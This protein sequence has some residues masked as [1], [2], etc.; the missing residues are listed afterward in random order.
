MKAPLPANEAQRL[1]TLR[2]YAVLDTPAELAYDDLALLAAQICQVPTAMVSLV[3][4]QRQWFKAR[5]G[6][7]ASE[8]SRD[9]AFCAHTILHADQVFEVRD[10]AADARF[11]ANPLVVSDPHMRFYAGA[12][13]VAPGGHA[14][15]ALCV[16][17][18][19]PRAL[20]AEQRSALQAL[21]R[22]VVA[23][24]ELRRQAREL[25]AKMAEGERHLSIAERSRRALLSILEDE[26]HAA[27]KLRESEARFRQIAENIQEVFWITDPAKNAILYVSPAYESIWGRPCQSLYDEPRNWLEAIHGDDRAAV[28][29]AAMTRQ[30]TGDYHETYRIMR[31]DG[32]PRWIR[33]RAFPVRNDQGEVYRVVGIAVDITEHK[34]AELRVKVQQEVTAVLAEAVSVPE[35][36]RRILEIICQRMD[37]VAGDLWIEDRATHTLRCV[38]IWHQPG[39]Q[40][41]AFAAATR[42]LTFAEGEGLPGRVWSKR[43]MSWTP[44]ISQDA[45]FVRRAHAVALG[46]RGAIAIP[47][48]LHGEAV[49][50]VEFFS[51]SSEEPEAQVKSMFAGFGTQ[52]GQFIERKHLEEQFRQAQKMEAIGTLAGGIAHDFNNVLSAITGYTELARLE[53]KGNPEV[54]EYLRAVAEGSNRAAD[55]VRQILAFSRLQEPRRKTIQLWPVVEEALKLLRATIPSTIEFETSLARGG[56][57]VLADPTQV[58]QVLM[59]LATNAAHA[60]KDRPGRLGVTL[61]NLEVDAELASTHPGLRVGRYQR[62]AVSDNGHG[63]DAGTLARI[64]DPFFTTKAPGEG[65]GLGLAVVHG[66]MQA[67]EGVITVYSQPGEGTRF[68]LYFPAHTEGA[69]V[70]SDATGEIPRGR[71]QHILLVDDE[72]PLAVMGRRILE[73]LGYVVDSYTAPADAL[74]A[75]RAAPDRF[76]LVV[77]DLTMPGMTGSDLAERLL[78][79]RPDLPIILTTGF[80]ATLTPER[81]R[82]LGVRELLLKPLT[83]QALGEAVHRTINPQPPL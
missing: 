69:P 14:L 12:P 75:V 57:T 60:M 7:E 77:S 62:L 16:M 53:A 11:A 30:V 73:R 8:T 33:D 42:P 40:Y 64:F 66:I 63:M 67:H 2:D 51:R 1:A 49:G 28:L 79:L 50:V 59:N 31:P 72:R 78:R 55:L 43:Q 17:D 24:L 15:G 25:A 32:T 34:R 9:I 46:L 27:R 23:Q 19:S 41:A 39:P 45:A 52:I 71:G 20:T 4:D 80:S 76:A 10:A 56:L 68:N 54:L 35:T 5:V 18:R 74:E 29:E 3:D 47:I 61:E 21:S 83:V 44:D 58:H 26:K 81:V 22:Q 36:A 65:T 70:A 6:M 37:W 48:L 13:L 38:D 82:A